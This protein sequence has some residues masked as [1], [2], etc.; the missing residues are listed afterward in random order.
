LAEFQH[1]PPSERSRCRRTISSAASCRAS[2]SLKY[3]FGDLHNDAVVQGLSQAPFMAD[4]AHW[5]AL[6]IGTG[7]GNTRFSNRAATDE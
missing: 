6:T 5:G 7:L 1:A 3:E 4:V 2:L